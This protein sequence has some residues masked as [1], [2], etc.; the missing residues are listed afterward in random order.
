M[1]D[2]YIQRMNE[3]RI[4]DLWVGWLKP[5]QRVIH[6]WQLDPGATQGSVHYRGTVVRTPKLIMLRECGYGCDTTVTTREV[7]SVRISGRVYVLQTPRF[8]SEGH[9]APDGERNTV[10]MMGDHKLPARLGECWEPLSHE[11]AREEQAAYEAREESRA[12]Q[13]RLVDGI[14]MTDTTPCKWASHADGCH[15]TCVGR[16]PAPSDDSTCP[17][18]LRSMG[19]NS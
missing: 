15:S 18:P 8:A 2:D 16:G 13:A 9:G 4:R 6:V 11:D 7:E 19:D 10:T 5:G 17:E 1:T 12:Q 3:Q 14:G